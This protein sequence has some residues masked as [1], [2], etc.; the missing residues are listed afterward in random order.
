M[1]IQQ[2]TDEL[3][4]LADRLDTNSGSMIDYCIGLET[5]SKL[6]LGYQETRVN[7]GTWDAIALAT[8]LQQILTAT[9]EDFNDDN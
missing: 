9:Q 3:R 5:Y 2:L 7:S 1:S 8:V 4:S 6:K